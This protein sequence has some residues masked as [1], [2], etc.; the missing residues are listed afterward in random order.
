MAEGW[1]IIFE[2]DGGRYPSAVVHKTKKDAEDAKN[3]RDQVGEP[4]DI[5]KI[6]WDDSLSRGPKWPP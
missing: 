3:R 6:S 1:I 5:V 2:R 4:I